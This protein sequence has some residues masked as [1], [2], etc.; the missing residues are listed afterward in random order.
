MLLFFEVLCA[1]FAAVGLFFLIREAYRCLSQD[2]G[3]YVCLYIARDGENESD[4]IKVIDEENF[5]GKVVI[6][7]GNESVTEK[8]ITD[9]CMRYGRVYIKRTKSIDTKKESK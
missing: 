1:Y 5:A 9:L 6:L 7:F 8:K 2:N 4:A 3:E